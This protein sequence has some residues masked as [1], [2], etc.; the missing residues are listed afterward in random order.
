[1]DNIKQLLINEFKRTEIDIWIDDE[2]NNFA[3]QWNLKDVLKDQ[4]KMVSG[5][6]NFN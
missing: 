5:K 2:V 3:A 6:R 4:Q 1:M